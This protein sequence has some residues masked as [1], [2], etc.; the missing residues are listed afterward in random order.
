MPI[1]ARV[2]PGVVQGIRFGIHTSGDRIVTVPREP[3][4]AHRCD[5][6]PCGPGRHP[7]LDAPGSRVALRSIPTP[8]R[9]VAIDE[10]SLHPNPPLHCSDCSV[11]LFPEPTSLAPPALSD[12]VCVYRL[13]T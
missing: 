13:R 11:F 5:T 1:P 7:N 6:R 4:H 2:F 10:G 9:N 12:P 8:I 3:T